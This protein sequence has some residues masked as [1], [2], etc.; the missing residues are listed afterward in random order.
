[1]RCRWIL[2][3]IWVYTVFSSFM[4]RDN[5]YTNQ[6]TTTTRWWMDNKMGGYDGYEL[7]PNGDLKLLNWDVFIGKSWSRHENEFTFEIISRTS[8]KLMV[9]HLAITEETADKMTVTEQALGSAYTTHLEKITHD[10]FSDAFLGHWDGPGESYVQI[11]P[12]WSFEFQVVM[13][14]NNKAEVEKYQGYL[15]EE[16]Q[17]I[18]VEIEDKEYLITCKKLKE[19]EVLT[20]NGITYSRKAE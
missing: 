18:R 6:Y 17:A 16:N 2:F 5:G 1:M 14:A 9:N 4:L 7:R 11:I 13:S 15:D 10:N 8:G 20:L 12:I 19:T 3:C